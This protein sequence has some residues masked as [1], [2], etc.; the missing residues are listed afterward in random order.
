FGGERL[1]PARLKPWTSR[2]S[3]S[4][5]ALINMY[6]ITETTVHVTFHR[7]SAE[8]IDSFMGI[9]PVGSAIPETKIYIFDRYLIPVPVGVAGE[10]YVGGTGVCRGYLNRPALTAEK[11]V[12]APM[13]HELS[14][15]SFLYK[16]GDLGSWQR[17]GNLRY[18]GRNDRQVK[19]RG[20][21]IELG[22]IENRLAAHETVKEVV[23]DVKAKK[24]R[25]GDR[26]L[27]AYIVP[28]REAPD[29]STGQWTDTLINYLSA[30]LPGYMIPVY[31]VLMESMP[32]TSSRKVD[33]NALPEPG[34][35]GI[36]EKE[37]MAPRDE[38]ETQLA[39]IWAGILGA[40]TVG[41][42]DNF[43]Q[44]G[45]H[46][47]KAA[48]MIA[49]VHKQLAVKIPLTDVFTTPTIRGL[50]NVIRRLK[51]E[52]DFPAADGFIA[53][54][55]AEEREYY[56]LI[57]A[58]KRLYILYRLDPSITGYNMPY[59]VVLKGTFLRQRVEESFRGLIRRHDSFRT[60]FLMVSGQPVQR[61][62]PEVEFEIEYVDLTAR[63]SDEN[64]NPLELFVRPFD[65]ERPPL[66]RVA[67]L[68][69]SEEQHIL[70]LDMHHIIT[71]GASHPIFVSDFM[72]LYQGHIPAPLP[73][74]YK[75]FCLWYHRDTEE[76]RG[77]G[78]LKERETF[79][80]DCFEDEV[81]VLSLPYDYPRSPVQSFEGHSIGFLPGEEVA[82]NLRALALKENVTLYMLL[83][84]SFNI[85][86]SRLSGQEDV[87]VGSPVAGRN[88]AD[89]QQIIGMFVNTLALRNYPAGSLGFSTFLRE[90]KRSA[91]AAFENQDYPFENLVE[92]V[93]VNRDT[94]RNPLFDVMFVLQNTATGTGKQPGNQPPDLTMEPYGF[95]TKIS[96]FD[97]TLNADEAGDRLYFSLEYC[98][99]LFN[100]ETVR[101]F[102]RY[103]REILAQLAMLKD[104]GIPLCEIDILSA[105]EKEQLLVDFNRTETAYPQDKTL[106]GLFEEQADGTPDRIA[107][108]G[109]GDG[110][111]LTYR[112]LNR[113]SH[114]LGVM[115]NRNGTG[116]NTIVALMMD[117]SVE[118]A[119]GI[120]GVLKA[121]AAYL[122]I[123]TK[124]PGERIDFMLK[125][126]A[127]KVI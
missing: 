7:L 49:N 11:F 13:S 71:D 76:R 92:R 98:T 110:V 29:K 100:E 26:H 17:D 10:L 55:P 104:P 52:P 97:L 27:C 37:Y 103:F 33:R 61:V 78:T 15:M 96:K 77:K 69:K 39:G 124:Y 85:L 84:A 122:P 88:H 36:M 120:L 23:V 116:T 108:A 107:V 14:A 112:E 111:S 80:L 93:T 28:C 43:F 22:E 40:E 65:L 16:T 3:L 125:D 60:S 1:D 75:D 81:P 5:I 95:E 119:V 99:R 74:Q 51:G 115:L 56:P 47:L 58:Q 67:V 94:G 123:D 105:E 35:T 42:D 91:L 127:A 90:V 2:Y 63:G 20:F 48:V 121:G 87:V 102:A 24:D 12:L 106:H 64:G 101:R 53:V 73:L 126:S 46:S 114:R 117:R 89:L 57:P 82:V 86:L 79:W 31:I 44:L 109:V 21:R 4:D 8:D 113:H 54:E 30:F 68:R 18:L 34:I 59:V 19:I 83:L 6:G 66:L 118:M 32:L 50:A 9:S 45:G 25:G 38:P 41:I 62:H 70:M 72:A